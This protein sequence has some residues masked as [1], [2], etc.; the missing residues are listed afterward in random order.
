MTID[1]VSITESVNSFVSLAIGYIP[2]GVTIVLVP[3]AFIVGVTFA[4]K[5]ADKIGDAFG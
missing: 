4:L 5:L 3:T 2:L 1:T